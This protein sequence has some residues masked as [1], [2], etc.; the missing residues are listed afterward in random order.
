MHIIGTKY[1]SEVSIAS[2][3]KNAPEADEDY[4]LTLLIAH[5]YALSIPKLNKDID[6]DRELPTNI[7]NAHHTCHGQ[8]F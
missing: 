7:S 4:L 6:K 5:C 8:M 1:N 3:N 2:N